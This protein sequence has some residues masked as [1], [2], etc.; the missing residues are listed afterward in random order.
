MN[1]LTFDIEDWFHTHKDRQYYSGHIWKELPSR[2]EYNTDRILSM[3]EEL[4][5]KATFFVL[6]WVAEH[7]PKLVKRIYNKGHEIAAHSYWHHNATLIKPEDFQKDLIRC[8]ARLGDVTGEP[9][10]IYRA[11]GFSLR[12][13]NQWAF[14]ILASNGIIADSSVQIRKGKINSPFIIKT[15]EQEIVEF[16]LITTSFGLPYT[17]GGYFRA[18]PP[19]LIS[20]F[21]NNDNYKLLYFHPRD[22][23]KD[24]PYSNLFSLFRNWLNKLNTGKCIDKL[25]PILKQKPVYTI[26]Q[27]LKD[28]QLIL[29]DNA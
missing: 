21:F 2:I 5:I 6:G 11:P 24:N 29:T 10:K 19:K 16:P 1:I 23:D 9:V 13:K 25:V 22:V 26:G 28:K 12:I 20:H 17:G 3:L 7:H 27:V 8:V 18:I 14:E 15:E 4:D